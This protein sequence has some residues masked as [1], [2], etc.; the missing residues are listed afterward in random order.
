[1]KRIM[2]VFAGP[3]ALAAAGMATAT[4]FSVSITGSGFTPQTITLTRGDTVRW[5][6]NDTGR[7]RIVADDGT[8][9]SPTLSPGR[10][11]LA[12]LPGRRD[13]QVPRRVRDGRRGR[14]RRESAAAAARAG[15]GGR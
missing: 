10:P 5:T 14:R 15:A 4:V 9:T 1:M 3:G 2:L 7:H 6:N 11:L 12:G 8:F 13:V